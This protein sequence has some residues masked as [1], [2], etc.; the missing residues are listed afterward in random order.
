MTAVYGRA[1]E[2]KAL[3]RRAALLAREMRARFPHMAEWA[4]LR[5]LA[6]ARLTVETLIDLEK[7]R[8]PG[9]VWVGALEGNR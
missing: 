8:G 6:V 2:A 7:Q 1:S 9:A 5:T 4:Y 3:N